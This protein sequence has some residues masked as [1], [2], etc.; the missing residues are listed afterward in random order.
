MSSQPDVWL[1]HLFLVFEAYDERCKIRFLRAKIGAFQ[2]V[3]SKANCSIG[4]LEVRPALQCE[5]PTL[6][7]LIVNSNV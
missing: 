4:T 3:F 1:G 2:Y 7:A 5:T 6:I